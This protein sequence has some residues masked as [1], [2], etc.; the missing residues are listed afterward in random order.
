MRNSVVFPEPLE[1]DQRMRGRLVDHQ[2]H[3]AGRIVSK[4]LEIF[5]RLE[6]EQVP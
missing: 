1:T 5:C 2:V 3:V 6:Q 4:V